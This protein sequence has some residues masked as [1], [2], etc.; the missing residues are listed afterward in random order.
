MYVTTLVELRIEKLLSDNDV[1]ARQITF[2]QARVADY[3]VTM[4]TNL[5]EVKELRQ[6]L[7]AAQT[8]PQDTG[9][10][11]TAITTS[12]H[13]ENELPKSTNVIVG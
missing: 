7:S 3:Q 10:E 11:T 4:L 2:Y 8:A 5:M 6:F 13:A 1:M 12:A 9:T